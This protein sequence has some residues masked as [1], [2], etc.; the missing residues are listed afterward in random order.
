MSRFQC[1]LTRTGE[2]ACTTYA[3]VTIADLT[4]ATAR[5]CLW[6][7]MAAL[8]GINGACVDWDDTRGLNE[9][10]QKAL[11]LTEEIGNRRV[12]L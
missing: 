8:E 1:V 4:G 5:G 2:P 11:E 10:E 6:H 7:A 9:W 3:R 12:K